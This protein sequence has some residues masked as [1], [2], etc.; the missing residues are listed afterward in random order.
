MKNIL[1]SVGPAIIVA[2]VVLGPGSILTSSQ[3]GATTGL[4]GLLV[5]VV[6]V[7][8]MIAMVALSA[9]LGAVY[10]GSIGDELA[11]RIGRPLTV[12]VGLVLFVIIALFQSSNN[13]ALIGGMEPL[14]A[15]WPSKGDS[16]GNTN[17]DGAVFGSAIRAGILLGFNALIILSLYLLRNLYQSVENLMKL[18][19]GLT[20]VA[21]VVNFVVAFSS[22]RTY[23]PIDVVTPIDWIPL[24]G[25][26]GTTFSVAGA[27]YQAYLVKEKGWGVAE[28]RR[29]LIDSIVSIAVLGFV[30]SIILVT[31]WRVFYGRPNPVV[32]DSVGD[33][34]MQLEPLF[35]SAAKSVFCVGILAGAL[36]SFLVNAMIAG[37]VLSDT[38]GWGAKLTDRWPLHFTTMALAV[39][40]GIAISNLASEDSTV[41]LITLAQALTV[42]GVPALALALIYLGTRKE[43]TGSRR[44]PRAILV[45]AIV[46][47]AVS[48][49]TACLTTSKVY[50]KI[51]ASRSQD[52]SFRHVVIMD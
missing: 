11:K 31:A 49:G 21:F 32:L 29:G 52:V 12:A 30:T 1:R 24:L 16:S 45:L 38:L 25:M 46:G 33:V 9:R 42:L 20:T 22:Q 36:S 2:A 18:L 8:L 51:K 7:V 28:I 50:Q 41:H 15:D 23:Q 26:I 3:V 27:F 10:E 13:I 17:D 14:L 35:G 5:I 37:T 4:I 6:S 39:G 47:F 43:L 19:I 40:G 44:V 48:C 34:A